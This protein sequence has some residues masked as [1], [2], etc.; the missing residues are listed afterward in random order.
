V[1]ADCFATALQQVGLPP[2][3]VTMVPSA[4]R[5]LATELV[6]MNGRPDWSFRAR[7]LP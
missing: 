5:A 7:E 3:A 4:D 1:I 2:A 6:Q